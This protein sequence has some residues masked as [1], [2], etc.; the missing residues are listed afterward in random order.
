MESIIIGIVNIPSIAVV[1]FLIRWIWVTSII[2]VYIAQSCFALAAERFP[3]KLW[4]NIALL[5]N[6]FC[7]FY[8]SDAADEA[9]G[10]DIREALFT[11]H[12]TQC[13]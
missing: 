3:E 6:R 5:R 7:T 1:G 12:H 11:P 2:S 8:T 4:G 13:E 9:D 10:V